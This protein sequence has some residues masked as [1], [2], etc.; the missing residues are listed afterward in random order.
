MRAVRSRNTKPE[1]LVRRTL[2]RLGFRFRL[3]RKDLPGSPDVV[4]PK[5]RLCIFVHG[6][7]WHRHSGCSRASMPKTNKAFWISKFSKNVARDNAAREALFRL[8]WDV[9]II[10]E[11]EVKN[12][13]KLELIIRSISE[14]IPAHLN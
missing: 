2:H 11:C 7:F 12:P 14:K 9:L 13:E 4:L 5:Y 1:V 8:G 10:W 3:H 6:C